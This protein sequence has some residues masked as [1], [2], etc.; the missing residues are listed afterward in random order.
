MFMLRSGNKGNFDKVLA[1]LLLSTHV[2]LTTVNI[3]KRILYI[4][5]ICCIPG[6]GC[7]IRI[8]CA[9]KIAFISLPINL[10]TCVLGA[11]KNRLIL[12]EK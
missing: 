7:E 6:I 12:V 2:G 11:Q 10:N 3:R 5:L 4:F 8:V 9:P 1:S